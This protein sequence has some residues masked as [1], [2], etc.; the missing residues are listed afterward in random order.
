MS[1]NEGEEHKELVDNGCANLAV[2]MF[3]TEEGLFTM[4]PARRTNMCDQKRGQYDPRFR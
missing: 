4:F 2:Q 3:G 1:R